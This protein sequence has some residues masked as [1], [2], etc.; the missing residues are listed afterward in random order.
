[1]LTALP[2]VNS[3]ATVKS[4]VALAISVVDVLNIL[5]ICL[6]FAAVAREE[7]EL[8]AVIFWLYGVKVAVLLLVFYGSAQL[9]GWVAR[10]CFCGVRADGLPLRHESAEEHADFLAS[11][12]FNVAIGSFLYLFLFFYDRDASRQFERLGDRP[13]PAVSL[14]YA[15]AL[16][17]AI[18]SVYISASLLR[19]GYSN[20]YLAVSLAMSSFR[21][22]LLVLAFLWV[23]ASSLI[24]HLKND[25]TSSLFGRV[26]KS[27]SATS[28]NILQDQHEHPCGIEKQGA[29]KAGV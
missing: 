24:G 17:K 12:R 18:F 3:S 15:L 8:S 28:V 25:G 21:L 19:S 10:T 4:A 16:S 11:L 27:S 2:L 1:M 26:W 29:K 7:A 22:A 20:G 14:V 23:R 13:L 9:P 5:Y 6:N